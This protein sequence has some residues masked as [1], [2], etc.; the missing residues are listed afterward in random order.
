MMES[1]LI[2]RVGSKVRQNHILFLFCFLIFLKI[3]SKVTTLATSVVGLWN[4]KLI[5]KLNTRMKNAYL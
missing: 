5:L 1:H 3:P 4:R 2:H